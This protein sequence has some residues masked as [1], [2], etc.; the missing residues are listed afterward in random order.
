MNTVPGVFLEPF[1]LKNM[2]G[3]L[4]ISAKLL[5]EGFES[6]RIQQ[7]GHGVCVGFELLVGDGEHVVCLLWMFVRSEWKG[8]GESRQ[9]GV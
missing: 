1:H 2:L 3:A 4:E 7:E 6:G 5:D 9:R 8:D